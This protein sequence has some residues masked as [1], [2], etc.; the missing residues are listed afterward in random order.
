MPHFFAGARNY[1]G[2]CVSFAVPVTLKR[3]MSLVVKMNKTT[4]P[5]MHHNEN[6]Q[7]DVELMRLVAER[8]MLAYRR[9]VEKYLNRV[10][11]FAERILGDYAAAEDMAQE[12]WIKVWNEAPRWQPKAKFSTWLYQVLM[13]SCIDYKR[14]K[15]PV[16]FAEIEAY[17]ESPGQVDIIISR[18]KAATVRDA[19]AKLPER[20]QI[21]LAL[22]YYEE[23]SNQ[24]AAEILGVNTGTL[25]Q[26]LFRARKNLKEMLENNNPGRIAI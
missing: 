15:R 21:A 26:L 2:G 24:K 22:C 19:M 17:D 8:D 9:L 12:L 13:N 25:Q 20:Q 6:H 14:K 23:M 7:E 4:R 16:N 3:G 11:H 5:G 18:Q 10:L 1:Y